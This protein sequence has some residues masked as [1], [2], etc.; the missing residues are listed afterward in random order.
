MKT[1]L[2]K[3]KAADEVVRE[4]YRHFDAAEEAAVRANTLEMK[5]AGKKRIFL[6][7]GL[8]LILIAN[9]IGILIAA[10]FFA[11]YQTS[12]KSTAETVKE[13][14]WQAAAE[15]KHAEDYLNEHMSE[16]GFL[17][18]AYRNPKATKFLVEVVESGEASTLKKALQL[19]M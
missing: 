6:L 2:E 3:L 13:L 17:E 7:L 18:V 10:V 11:V 8:L 12:K 14:R 15:Q 9:F 5:L 16:V 1:L 19:Y 4:A